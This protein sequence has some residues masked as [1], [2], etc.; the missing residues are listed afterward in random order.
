MQS[1]LK[2]YKPTRPEDESFHSI[3]SIILH[4]CEFDQDPTDVRF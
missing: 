1:L 4:V 2:E 3:I